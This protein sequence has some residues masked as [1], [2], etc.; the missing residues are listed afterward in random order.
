MS[1]V[2]KLGTSKLTKSRVLVCAPSN[3]AL[4]EIVLRVLRHGLRDGAG[5]K[6]VPNIVRAGVAT[7]MHSSIKSVTLE[8]LIS[9]LVGEGAD[10][11]EV[12]RCTALHCTA[13]HCSALL[14][15]ALHYSALI[16]TALHCPALHCSALLCTALLCTALLCSALLCSALHCSALLCSA[17]LC[18]ALHC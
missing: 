1:P 6:V 17:L 4:D 5:N 12:R 18:T 11:R 8:V 15:T 9:Q 16:C 7:R 14:C 10:T 13:L 2:I 3:A